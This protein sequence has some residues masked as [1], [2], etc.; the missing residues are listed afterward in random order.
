MVRYADVS[1]T[2]TYPIGWLHTKPVH[3]LGVA[4]IS[5]STDVLM[6][7]RRKR[8]CDRLVDAA[9]AIFAEQGVHASSVEA[10]CDRAGFT[11]GAFYSNFTTKEELFVALL[12][13]RHSSQLETLA[14]KVD[15][16]RP[17]LEAL[18]GRLDEDALAEMLL[19]FFAEREGDREWCLIDHEFALMSLREPE[20]AAVF[21]EHQAAFERSLLTIVRR[22]LELAGRQF[23]LPDA[24]VVR[25]VGA[26]YQ[27][28]LQ[29]AIRAGRTMREQ[30][31]ARAT[32][33]RLV[34]ALTQPV[35]AAATPG[36]SC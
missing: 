2:E 24:V 18:A 31:E 23:V 33:V 10:V 32:M 5:S 8:T 20:M 28:M 9:F 35:P 36:T 21:E 11:R 7:P 19:D 1:D 13:R 15:G 6:T 14:E 34:L 17:R 12:E 3:R 29:R 26:L 25:L 4:R 27:D 16:V 30:P 22:A